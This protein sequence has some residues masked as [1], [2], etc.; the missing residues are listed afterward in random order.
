MTQ[1]T[2]S[3]SVI[4]DL[5]V[6]AAEGRLHEVQSLLDG[7]R[8]RVNDENEVCTS[9][10]STLYSVFE[11]RVV[12]AV[13]VCLSSKSRSVFEWHDCYLTYVRTYFISYF[14]S[15]ST[16]IGILAEK[17]AFGRLHCYG[18]SSTA[19]LRRRSNDCA[20]MAEP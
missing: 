18:A 11:S 12:F 14:Y 8:C 7:G 3:A 1:A 4:K 5:L 19:A 2:S 17:P 15:I 13:C 6:A 10:G 16:N 20:A 9:R